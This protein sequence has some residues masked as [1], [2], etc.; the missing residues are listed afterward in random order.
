FGWGYTL[1]LPT[2][3]CGP[4][5]GQVRLKL[6]FDPAAG[7]PLYTQSS[8]LRINSTDTKYAQATNVP[9]YGSMPHQ[10]A[11]PMPVGSP[12][13]AST[14]MPTTLTPAQIHQMAEQIRYG[15]G[16]VAPLAAQ[17]LPVMPMQAQMAPSPVAAQPQA[18]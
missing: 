5:L 10:T 7:S 11:S 1:A 12:M 16:H 3:T 9:G 18:F 13:S 14:P 8:S 2:A 4:H 15:P 6:E 17:P